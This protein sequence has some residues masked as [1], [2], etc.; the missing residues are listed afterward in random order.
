MKE[1][2]FE[3]KTYYSY[4]YTNEFQ[5]MMKWQ[6]L[7]PLKICQV[8]STTF[9]K[10]ANKISEWCTIKYKNSSPKRE[11]SYLTSINNV[12]KEI[13]LDYGRYVYGMHD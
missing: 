5:T 7:G 12:F 9:F 2:S 3:Y 4:H 11:I 10:K 6:K 8:H 13:N 1:V